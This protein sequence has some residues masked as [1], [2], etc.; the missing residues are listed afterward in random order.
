M[1]AILQNIYI[2]ALFCSFSLISQINHP[3]AS[4]FAQ[5][6][7]EIGLSKVSIT[8]SRP[9]ARGR[10]VIGGLVPYGRIWRVGA[11][12]STKISLD[13]D[14][15]IH[16]HALSKGV[17]AVYAFPEEKEWQIVFHTNVSHWGD[18]RK[19]YN[20][21]E[22]AFRIKVKPEKIPFHQENFLIAFD[23]ITHNSANLN[24]LWENTKLTI[25]MYVDTDSQMEL[26]IQ[27]QLNENPTA[28][29]Y[30]E[31]ARYLQEQEKDFEKALGYLNKALE[32]GG[33]TYYFHRVK[34]LVQAELRDF[35]AAIS[36][37]KKSLKIASEL[38]K[39][40]FVRMNEINIKRWQSLLE[41]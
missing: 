19:N 10:K 20:P 35:N 14:F 1:K 37:A 23:S 9:S 18:G 7:Q 31:A 17:Y 22:D 27:R 11:N 34:S 41:K 33:D 32:I 4:P 15:M 36:S 2:L 29:T 30:Y 39:D 21:E 38:E 8:Y 12:E 40:E 26:E 3:K 25:P 5:V 6:A 28:Q 24:L 13:T 16:G